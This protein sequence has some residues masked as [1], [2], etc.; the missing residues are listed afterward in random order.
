MGR[1]FDERCHLTLPTARLVL[2]GL[3]AMGGVIASIASFLRVYKVE[4]V[5]R[6]GMEEGTSPIH[7]PTHPPTYPFAHSSSFEPPPSP[8]SSYQLTHPPLPTGEF[9]RAASSL[10]QWWN[11][12]VMCVLVLVVVRPD[13][14]RKGVKELSLY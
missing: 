13:W 14:V 7:P 12:A 1:L 2:G 3:S 10:T 5:R 8:L 6:E 4:F 11:T 9:F